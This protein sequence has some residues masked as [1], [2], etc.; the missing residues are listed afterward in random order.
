MWTLCLL[1]NLLIISS[2]YAAQVTLSWDP[3]GFNPYQYR[4]YQRTEGAAYDFN[5]PVWT[6]TATTCTIDGLAENT[7]YFFVIRS[8]NGSEQGNNSIEINHVASTGDD[9]L[10][11]PGG[12]GIDT[13]GDGIGNDTDPDDDNDGMPDA[14]EIQY[15]LD[16]LVD[17]A[18]LDPDG[19]GI[20]N[21]DEYGMGTD[22]VVSNTDA[23]II[24]DDG[25]AG[26]LPSGLWK[27]SGGASPY[28]TQSIYSTEMGAT[29]G[30]EAPLTGRYEVAMW[31]TYYST[32]CTSVPVEIYDGATLIDTIYLNQLQQA[33]GQWTVLG[34]YDFSGSALVMVVAQDSSCSTGADA[35]QFTKSDVTDIDGDGVDDAQ[36]AF[37]TDAAEWSDADGDG[38]G[39]NADTDDD[40]DGMPDAWETQYGLDPLADDAQLD[41]DG[42]G[43][44]NIDE[45]GMGT[46]PVVGDDNVS[47]IIDDGDAGTLPSGIWKVSKG[48]E[49][50]GSQ[51]L[52]SRDVG[53]TYGYEAPLAGRY[54][55]ALYWTY[56]STRCQDVSVEIYDGDLLLDTLSV[57]Q[58]QSGGQWN[59]LGT[60]EFTGR[61]EVVIIAE[62]KY[63]TTAVDAARFKK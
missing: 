32:R 59:V 24:I 11:S 15:G 48:A 31:W 35:M 42:D 22:P 40:N 19:D 7:Q 33:G 2:A 45:Y 30:Y 1:V 41:P 43:F 29:Y 13:D 9:P 53:A 26:T 58:L 63:C 54:E 8:C 10:P 55:V 28:G 36:D 52:Y 20:A 4:I 25:D 60:Y 50:Y 21:I 3:N 61:A 16:P 37:P 12:D 27:I 18:Q 56:H 14:W 62:S 47:I 39:D 46:D 5:T 44:A 38:I 17:D 49:P 23:P 6:G 57:N 34:T 51:S